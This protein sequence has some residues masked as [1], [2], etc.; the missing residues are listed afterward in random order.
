MINVAAAR[1]IKF[2]KEHQTFTVANADL[3]IA[4][5]IKYSDF[6]GGRDNP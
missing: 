6:M 3:G 2:L 1:S 5:N 4:L